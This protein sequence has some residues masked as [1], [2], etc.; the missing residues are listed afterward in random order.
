MAAIGGVFGAPRERYLLW[1]W[2]VAAEILSTSTTPGALPTEVEI[3]DG[4]S[5]AS[6][7]SP[8]TDRP[9]LYPLPQPSTY[10]VPVAMCALMAKHAGSD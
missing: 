3:P 2:R 1:E 10:S 4:V 6:A 9:N 5:G 7:R 8:F